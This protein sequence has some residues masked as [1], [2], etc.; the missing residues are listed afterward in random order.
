MLHVIETTASILTK[1]G[2][3]TETT[4]CSSWVAPVG[5]QQIQDNGRPPF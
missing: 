5:A 2:E 3:T 1:F 4:E